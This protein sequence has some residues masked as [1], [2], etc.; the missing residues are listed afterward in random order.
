[1][2]QD[3]R[4]DRPGVPPGGDDD[5]VTR[6]PGLAPAGATIAC[7]PLPALV[8]DDGPPD[9]TDPSVLR[10]GDSVQAYVTSSHGD[11]HA[12][13]PGSIGGS[14]PSGVGAGADTGDGGGE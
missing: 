3:L 11:P 7:A 2:D 6:L 12:G 9:Y 8:P 10:A 4:P 13:L 5:L 14:G 1:M